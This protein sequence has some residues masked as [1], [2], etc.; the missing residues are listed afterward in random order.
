V[1][2]IYYDGEAVFF[3][4][5]GSQTMISIYDAY[6][7]LISQQCPSLQDGSY[8][9]F[10]RAHI[11]E[12]DFGIYVVNVRLKNL[13]YSLKI[14]NSTRGSYETGIISAS[15]EQ[16]N[17]EFSAPNLKATSE[18]HSL[19]QVDKLLFE[20]SSYEPQEVALSSYTQ[21]VG[22]VAMDDLITTPED[23]SD[24]EAEADNPKSVRFHWTD[25]SNNETEFEI[26]RET[27]EGT[28]I[29]N[30]VGTTGANAT[31]Y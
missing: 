2:D 30:Q 7:R 1:P 18:L 27:S 3:V 14:L 31:S 19:L 9:F 21:N 20:H 6:G 25:N 23:P 22:V 8:K 11:P 24:L 16:W 13:E 15:S 10:P 4:N 29:Y 26:W 17:P 28:G 5:K 12:S